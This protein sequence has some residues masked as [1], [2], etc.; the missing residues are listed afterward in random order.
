MLVKL[1]LMHTWVGVSLFEDGRRRQPDGWTSFK[2]QPQ[3]QPES[4]AQHD[5]VDAV[6]SCPPAAVGGG[7]ISNVAS[8]ESMHFDMIKSAMS[9]A[10]EG[11]ASFAFRASRRAAAVTVTTGS[12][13][14]SRLCVADVRMI[15]VHRVSVASDLSCLVG[16]VSFVFSL[17]SVSQCHTHPGSEPKSKVGQH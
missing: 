2:E 14:W 8:N 17:S 13:S 10:V 4:L 1:S 6:Y 3:G 12:L 7:F 15:S 5:A 9:N 11:S 16:P